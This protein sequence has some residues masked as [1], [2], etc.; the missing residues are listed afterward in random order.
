MYE[1][2]KLVEKQ[3]SDSL[4]YAIGIRLG[5]PL[6]VELIKIQYKQEIKRIIQIPP[7]HQNLRQWLPEPYDEVESPL[8][9]S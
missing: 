1:Q 7:A 9:E 6:K 2:R 3:T 5:I 8:N 4:G